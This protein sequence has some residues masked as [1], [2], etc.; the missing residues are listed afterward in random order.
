MAWTDRLQ[1]PAYTSPSGQRFEFLYEDVSME[2]EKKTTS[3]TFP[4]KDGAFIQD[5]GRAGRRF[6]FTIFFSGA[7]YDQTADAFAL[8]LEERGAGK[9]EHPLYGDRVVVPSG[10]FSREDRVTTGG[11]QAVFKVEFLETIEDITFPVSTESQASILSSSADSFQDT[12]AEKFSNDVQIDNASEAVSLQNTA[13]SSVTTIGEL[14][15]IT[16]QDSDINSSFKTVFASYEENVRNVILEA[17]DT[18]LQ[19]ILLTRIPSRV[20]T[21]IRNE[22]EMYQNQIESLITAARTPDGSNNPRNAYLYDNLMVSSYP[23]SHI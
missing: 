14:E 3:F 12:T 2:V 21:A 4:E 16:E 18:A 23:I 17:R 8:A 6:P 11:N 10:S 22:I 5:L 15:E 1:S 19:A 7:D 13:V 20:E 9:L